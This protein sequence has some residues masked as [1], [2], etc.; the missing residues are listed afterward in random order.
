MNP[1]EN[2]REKMGRLGRDGQRNSP[3]TAATIGQIP[4]RA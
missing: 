2:I 1:A 3:V 4:L